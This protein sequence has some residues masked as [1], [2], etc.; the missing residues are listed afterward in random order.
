MVPILVAGRMDGALALV[1]NAV[2]LWNTHYT[3]AAIAALRAASHPVTAI[4]AARLSPLL[5][6]HP[7]VHRRCSFTQP[8]GDDILA[9]RDPKEPSP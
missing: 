8:S 1:L 4:D 5:D 6:A 3:D 7:N 2:V 9:L